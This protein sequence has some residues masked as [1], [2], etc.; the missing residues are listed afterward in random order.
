MAMFTVNVGGRVFHTTKET[1]RQS[2]FFRNIF[3][4]CESEMNL[5]VDR[6]PDNFHQVLEFLRD[7]HYRFPSHLDYEL[8]Y[9]LIPFSSKEL[10]KAGDI[11]KIN[12]SIDNRLDAIET[13]I[14]SLALIGQQ[15]T[16]C[17]YPKCNER[18]ISP[19][20]VC[21]K[22]AGQ[23]LGQN[24]YGTCDRKCSLSVRYCT[25]HIYKKHMK[26][27]YVKIYLSF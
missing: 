11:E 23:C 9:Y 4:D 14:R 15:S 13:Q 1:L 27:S 8:K 26:Q 21:V 18:G 17:I 19:T 3:E 22:H 5:F 24:T 7:R 10:Y 25:L 16:N 6:S 20:M 2:E 12:K